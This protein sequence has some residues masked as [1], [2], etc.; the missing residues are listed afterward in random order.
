MSP[1]GVDVVILRPGAINTGWRAIVGASL[2]QHSGEGPYSKAVKAA[3]ST[4]MGP[5]FDKVV[6]DP[7]VIAKVVETIVKAKRPQSIYTAPRMA[8]NL[9]R[10]HNL[11]GSDR[12]RDAFARR[13]I[14]LPKTM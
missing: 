5:D 6:A 11:L 3:Y 7:K 12:L 9:V 8:R 14:G 13:F 1:F 10:M 2:L 4:F